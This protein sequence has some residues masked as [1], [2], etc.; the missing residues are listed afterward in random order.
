V[1]RWKENVPALVTATLY[2]VAI[3]SLFYREPSVSAIKYSDLFVCLSF[4]LILFY[5]RRVQIPK[6]VLLIL[7]S[8]GLAIGVSMLM[9]PKGSDIG[10]VLEVSRYALSVVLFLTTLF[11]L[12]GEI[13]SADEILTVCFLAPLP[14]AIMSISV[15]LMASF[16]MLIPPLSDIVLYESALRAATYF[17]D[18]NYYA[19]VLLL[20]LAISSYR[21]VWKRQLRFLSAMCLVIYF[22]AI[23][24]SGSRSGV[25]AAVILLSLLFGYV[26]VKRKPFLSSF[27]LFGSSIVIGVSTATT[28]H[29]F[30]LLRLGSLRS[31]GI[32]HA[33][34]VR[35][36]LWRAGFETWLKSPFFGVGPNNYLDT[37]RQLPVS[38]QPLTLQRTH[39]TVL[40][41]LSS[42][43]LLGL[44][45]LLLILRYHV[46]CNLSLLREGDQRMIVPLLATIGILTQGMF[47]EL[48]TARWLWLNLAIP[49]GVYVNGR[50]VTETKMSSKQRTH[51][52][53][54]R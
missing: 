32:D 15:V 29:V 9:S 14:S 30:S 33:L 44:L 49:I 35:F 53:E 43:G 27:A 54:N 7:L 45:P 51:T 26:A 41:V 50:D 23:V 22:G 10:S 25:G 18:P 6:H 19:N 5:L 24:A 37:L 20:P 8:L 36:S 39:N 17:A 42:L 3:S 16:G 47:I 1:S 28:G 12:L 13:V 2:F 48:V 52:K 46:M 38:Q 34:Q 11:L 21:V 31:T 4:I 40:D